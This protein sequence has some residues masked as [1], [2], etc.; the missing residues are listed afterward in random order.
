[1]P[2]L[3][4]S[5]YARA[6]QVKACAV[7]NWIRRGK[8]SGAALV[9]GRIDSE[10][11]DQQLGLTVDPVRQASRPKGDTPTKPQSPPTASPVDFQASRDLLRAR[12]TMAA[13]QAQRAWMELQHA[14][15]RYM[16]T[17]E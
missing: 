11:A 10:A 15:G 1:M 4:K 8:L 9:D 6:R 3:S 2:L 12:A 13:V 16:L 14:K 17:E 7:S 5:E